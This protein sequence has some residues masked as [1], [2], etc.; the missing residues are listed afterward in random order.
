MMSP[1]EK[2]LEKDSANVAFYVLGVLPS[3]LE[4]GDGTYPERGNLFADSST[5]NDC[6][7]FQSDSKTAGGFLHSCRNKGSKILEPPTWTSGHDA[8]NFF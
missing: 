6:D 3:R 7:R 1:K 5:D 8:G 2:Q 4:L